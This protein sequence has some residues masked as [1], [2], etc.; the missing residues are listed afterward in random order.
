MV[1]P[2][3]KYHPR[4]WVTMVNPGGV[5][6]STFLTDYNVKINGF[7]YKPPSRTVITIPWGGTFCILRKRP[8]IP[9]GIMAPFLIKKCTRRL[10]DT[11]I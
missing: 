3:V 9:H 2:G 6:F 7:S 10:E 5:V 4:G 1:N 11:K 8:K